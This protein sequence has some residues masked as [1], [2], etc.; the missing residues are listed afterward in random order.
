VKAGRLAYSALVYALL[1]HALV[2]LAWRARRQP[3][4]LKHVGERFGRYSEPAPADPVVW[5][6]AVSL[7]ETR[8]AEPLLRALA[9]R[10]PECRLLLTHMTPTGREA[11]RTLFGGSVV[12]AWLPYDY[13]AAVARFLDHFR[14]RLGLIMETE[15]WP[16]VVHACAAREIPLHLVNARL[17]EKSSRRYLRV[18]RLARETFQAFA[19]VAA[20][21]AADAERLRMVG[22]RRVVVTGNVKFDVT[23]DPRLIELGARWRSGYGA[24]PVLLA[25][26]TRMGEEALILE[27]WRA[28]APR[29]AL[30]VIVPRH[31]QRF[32]EVAALIERHGLTY[33][34]RSRELQ[35]LPDTQVVLGD[36]MGEMTAYY[37]SCD[38]ALI[39]GSL[40]PFGGQNLIEACAVGRPVLLGHHT[41]NF[42]DAA[43]Q[44][45]Q[46]GA[47][48][49]RADAAALLRAACELWAN[50]TA[51]RRMS[52][53]ALTFS[54]AHRGATERV[55]RAVLETPGGGRREAELRQATAREEQRR[56]TGGGK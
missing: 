18:A 46:A 12:Q 41:F 13:P 6:H 3:G 2:H 11:G 19:G 32:D 4:Y 17:S 27:A 44:A 43:A 21:S 14:P 30:L 40:L 42:S 51:L 20:Q 29:E 31:P 7:G 47:A 50:G 26:S 23:P 56:E 37:A 5:V 9:A 52:E 49:E 24:R 36:S 39:G 22:A 28:L 1:P 16:N 25:A 15:V 8:A 35:V 45:L 53:R 54:R 48:L 10:F 55:L 38:I 34:R 33:V